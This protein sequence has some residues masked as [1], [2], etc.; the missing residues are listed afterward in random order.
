M[1]QKVTIQVRVPQ[2]IRDLLEF[3]AEYHDM[4]ISEYVRCVLRDHLKHLPSKEET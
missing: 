4:T 1:E 3:E 2:R